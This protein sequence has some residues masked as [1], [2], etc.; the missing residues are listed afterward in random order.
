[1]RHGYVVSMHGK[2]RPLLKW[3]LAGGFLLSVTDFRPIGTPP[4]N[5][6]MR[7]ANLAI[8][9]CA[10]MEY[11]LDHDG[12]FPK[13]ADEASKA[14]LRPGSGYLR[15]DRLPT[16]PWW[17]RQQALIPVDTLLGPYVSPF[18]RKRVRFSGGKGFSPISQ[19]QP[20]A[21]AYDGSLDGKSFVLYATGWNRG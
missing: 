20:G 13:S 2:L 8:V 3:G 1:M 4:H 7:R 15:D 19:K 11:A 17:G 5:D 9:H 12:N 21:I 6:Y 10:L 14:L 18:D 16:T